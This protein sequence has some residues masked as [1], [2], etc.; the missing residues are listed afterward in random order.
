[1]TKI[2]NGFSEAESELLDGEERIGKYECYEN[3]NLKSIEEMDDDTGEKTIMYFKENG[4]REKMV[5]TDRNRT[6]ITFY[7]NNDIFTRQSFFN[8]KLVVENKF[9]IQTSDEKA[10]VKKLKRQGYQIEYPNYKTPILAKTKYYDEDGDIYRE[11]NFKK[12]FSK[13]FNKKGGVIAETKFVS[14]KLKSNKKLSATERML[15][16]I[17]SE[18]D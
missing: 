18:V 1:M 9:V 10:Y 12:G 11:D 14:S 15:N 8:D 3:G 4:E 6:L 5:Y 2:K 17:F 13:E 16:A 7:K